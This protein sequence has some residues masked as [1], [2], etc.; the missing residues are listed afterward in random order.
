MKFKDALKKKVK[1]GIY[2]LEYTEFCDL[3]KK[4]GIKIISKEITIK[5][6]LKHCSE[7]TTAELITVEDETKERYTCLAIKAKGITKVNLR[8]VNNAK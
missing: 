4:N 3:M 6:F 7:G 1:E 5:K 2:S 8:S